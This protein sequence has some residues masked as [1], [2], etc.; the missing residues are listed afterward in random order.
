[1]KASQSLAGTISGAIQQSKQ[2]AVANQLLNQ[3]NPPR[4][5]LVD[6][7]VN[8][9]TGT[10]NVIAPGVSTVGTAPA[11][12]GL[13]E[14]RLRQQFQQQQQQ[15]ALRQ[16]Q[17]AREL[18][19]AQGR[20]GGGRGG[21]GGGGSAGASRSPWSQAGRPDASKFIQS[22]QGDGGQGGGGGKGK[23]KGYVPGSSTSSDPEYY[24][25]NNQRADVDSRYGK[26]TFDRMQ[27]LSGVI[28]QDPKTGKWVSANPDVA[29]V[30]ADTGDVTLMGA[31]GKPGAQISAGDLTANMKRYD[32]TTVQQG[33]KPQYIGNYMKSQ[34]PETGKA[35]GTL[36]NPY[37]PQDT[38]DLN[39][40]PPGTYFVN[41]G[42]NRVHQKQPSQ[43]GGQ[44]AAAS[45]T[46]DTGAAADT[47]ATDTSVEDT[48]DEDLSRANARNSG[49]QL[50]QSLPSA[51]SVDFGKGDLAGLPQ[52]PVL[53]QAL[54]RAQAAQS[55]MV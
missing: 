5:G 12:G 7:G 51:P 50:A 18:M 19:L 40:I 13:A 39:A 53:A 34:A 25:Y 55:L 8:P 2:D 30:N 11:T 43:G 47:S 37:T 4:A 42:D 27:G 22:Q 45:T 1:M 15:D 17:T 16:A 23:A 46:T 21:G 14:L 44:K 52:D 54:R 32:A 31:G 9:Q 36:E 6:P 24:N 38:V 3:A 20:A 29:T 35:A 28:T 26:G 48:G 49:A 10:A 41:P 33:G